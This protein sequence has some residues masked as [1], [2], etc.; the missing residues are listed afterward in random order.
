MAVRKGAQNT[1]TA[2]GQLPAVVTVPAL[3]SVSTVASLLE[4]S[5][6]TVRRRIAEGSLPAVLDHGRPMVRGDDLRDYID[7]LERVGAARSRRESK[8]SATGRYDF[9]RGATEAKP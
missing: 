2:P 4:C 6:R 1:N 9:L 7:G 8:R 5:P 3:L